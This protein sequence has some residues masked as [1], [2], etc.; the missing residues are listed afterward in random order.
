M[1]NK[2]RLT[3]KGPARKER[4]KKSLT[5]QEYEAQKRALAALGLSSEEYQRRLKALRY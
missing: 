5:P 4:K 3:K 2:L 1:A